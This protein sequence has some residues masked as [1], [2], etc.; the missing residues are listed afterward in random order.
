[1]SIRKRPFR[2]R[3]RKSRIPAAILKA[4]RNRPSVGTGNRFREH[5]LTPVQTAEVYRLWKSR[6]AA[7]VELAVR[8]KISQTQVSRIVRSE[9]AKEKKAA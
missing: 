7:Q 3:N 8:F 6:E 5:P 2:P 4:Y 9:L 1:M